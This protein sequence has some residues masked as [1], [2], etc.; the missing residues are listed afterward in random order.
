MDTKDFV[1]V[2]L[3]VVFA[4]LFHIFVLKSAG[5]C[6][7]CGGAKIPVTTMSKKKERYTPINMKMELMNPTDMQSE[8]GILPIESDVQNY[9]S[10]QT[11]AQPDSNT[12][13][14]DET[15]MGSA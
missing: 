7:C 2:A 15:L 10:E 3:L 11:V 4:I 6:G 12:F 8:V 5:I 9:Y 13:L 14:I 1:L